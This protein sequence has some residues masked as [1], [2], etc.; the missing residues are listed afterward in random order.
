ME[1]GTELE[2]RADGACL[3]GPPGCFGSDLFV[4]VATGAW[5]RNAGEDCS[6]GS[7][8]TPMVSISAAREIFRSPCCCPARRVAE[9]S[10]DRSTT[11]WQCPTISRSRPASPDAIERLEVRIGRRLPAEY[12]SYLLG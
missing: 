8:T 12:R 4:A 2:G 3:R 6:C 10:C 11:S 1:G 9:R 5:S 7:V